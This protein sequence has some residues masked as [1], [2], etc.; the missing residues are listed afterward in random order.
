[1]NANAALLTSKGRSLRLGKILGKGG[2]GTIYEVEGDNSTAVKIYT[3]G[4]ALTRREKLNAMIADRLHERTP[5]VAFPIEAVT[6]HGAMVG[7]TMRKAVGAKPMHQLCSPGD[8]K[9]EFPDANFRFLVRAAL[10]FTRAVA[11]IND[12]GAVIGDINESGT[13]VD[14]KG[15]ITVIDSDSFQYRYNGQVFRCRVGKAEYTPPE[16]QGQAFDKVDRTINHDAFG[17]A[18][19]VFEILFMGRHPYSGIYKGPGEPPSI[20]K[21]IQDGRFA[22]S[23]HKSLTQMEPPP[24][25]PVMADIPIEVA[26]AFQRAFGLPRSTIQTRPTAADWVPLLENMEKGIIECKMNP[27]HFYSRTAPRCPWCR[28]EAGFGTVLFVHYHPL[29]R[30]TFALESILLKIQQVEN[31]GAAPNLTSLMPVA[32]GL[33]RGQAAKDAL[34]RYIVRKIAGLA[35]AGL[36]T[37]LMLNGTGWGFFILIPAAMWFFGGVAGVEAIHQQCSVAQTA[38]KD[39]LKHWDYNAGCGKFEGKQHGLLQTADSY[40]ALPQVEQGML[41]DLEKRKRDLQMQKH[42]E[43]YKL[44]GATI[45]LIGDGRKMTL[46]SFGIESAWDVQSHRIRGVP[47]FGPTLTQNLL[48]WRISVEKRFRFNP[49]LP[50]DAAEIARVHAEISMQRSKMETELLKGA[51]ELQAIRTAALALRRDVARYQATYLAFR[52]AELDARFLVKSAV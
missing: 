22:Y 28:F 18:V 32:R 50:T 34:G 29:R 27:A 15:L 14:Q 41:R 17:L 46:R 43:T 37:A 1:V 44:S 23:Q 5:F 7:F 4:K 47:G 6:A 26:A 38:W 19:I 40:R 12:L 16:L 13:L 10:N 35:A 51:N 31:P 2:E 49:N 3:D 24:H 8:R 25:V 42:L 39:A 52:Q 21:A 48:D 11:S 45:D 20:P 33:K 30:S 9:T 36:A